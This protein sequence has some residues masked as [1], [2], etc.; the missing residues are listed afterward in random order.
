MKILALE[1]SC[2][3]TAAA[4]VEDGRRV[5]ASVV[6]SQTAIH[7]QFGGVLPEIA[8]RHHLEAVNTVVAQAL[9]QAHCQPADIDAVAAT[10]GPGLIGSL[11]VGAST[12]K[13]LAWVWDKPFIG[14][15][16]L[17]GH[18]CSNYLNS[19][20]E[21]PF[22]CLLVSGGHTQ[23]MAVRSYTDMDVVGHTLD[24]A[25]GE[26]FDKVARLLGLPYPG[27]PH[28]DRVAQGGDP[29]RFVLPKA[30]T[31][32]PW[33]FSFSGLKTAV[34]RLYE[35]EAAL[36][37]GDSEAMA[38]L[39]A[40]M[41]ASFQA[42]VVETLMRKTLDCAEALRLSTVSIA[43]GV[44]AN[45]ALRGQ[46]GQ[47]PGHVQVVVPQLAYCMDNGAMMA[48]AAFYCPFTHDVG[49]DVFSRTKPTPV[50]R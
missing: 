29:R 15:H 41:A 48:S 4:V 33:D 35:K 39:Q 6:A 28:L 43:G 18:I 40:D 1:S 21:P 24:D 50:R 2:D 3:D 49:L 5:L 10:V 16:H 11:L 42:T 17:H 25:V 30:R 37:Q 45:S 7:A 27:G 26:A 22:L 14:V 44:S 12:A 8:A 36:C 32:R 13:T 19:E 23:L 38:K 47:V 20:L 34:S 31:A 9:E 46:L